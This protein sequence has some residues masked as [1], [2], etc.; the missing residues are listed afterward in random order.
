MRGLLSG[1]GGVVQSL[2]FEKVSG[3]H[4]HPLLTRGE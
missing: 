2:V 1:E 3:T 4:L